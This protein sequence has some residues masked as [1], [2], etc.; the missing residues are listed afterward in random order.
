MAASSTN[1][2]VPSWGAGDSKQHLAA[3]SNPENLPRWATAFVRSV[4]KEDNELDYQIGFNPM[5]VVASGSV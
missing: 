3:G 5:R 4:K 1:F 2:S